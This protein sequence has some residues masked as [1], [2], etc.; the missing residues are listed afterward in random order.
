MGLFAL[1]LITTILV[2][3][4]SNQI[5]ASDVNWIGKIISLILLV[6]LTLLLVE[7]P[8]MIY[9]F[10]PKRADNILLKLNGWIQERGQYLTSG[11]VIII[12]ICI[13]FNGLKE[14]NLI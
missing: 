7:I 5:A 2:F 14:L 11:L 6:V 8:L 1:N 12:G 4:G 9:L 3:F 10:A 13:L